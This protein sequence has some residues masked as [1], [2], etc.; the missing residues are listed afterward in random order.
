MPGPA[1]TARVEI[2]KQKVERLEKLPARMEAVELQILQLRQEM[3]ADFSAVQAEMNAMGTG[4]RMEIRALRE[5]LVVKIEA[6]DEETRRYMR[7]LHEDVIA[8]IETIS[9]GSRRQKK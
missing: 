5:E 2:L 6:G 1:L 8:K 3:R 4:M 7:V 9:G